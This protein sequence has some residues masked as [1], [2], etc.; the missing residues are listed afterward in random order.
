MRDLHQHAR[1]VA[2]ERVGA[3]GAAVLEVLQDPQRVGDDLVRLAPLHVG[4][5]ADAAGVVLVRGVVEA[6]RLRARR[7]GVLRGDAARFGF[8]VMLRPRCGDARR[9]I[10]HLPVASAPLR[11]D[12]TGPLRGSSRF[13]DQKAVRSELCGQAAVGVCTSPSL[14]AA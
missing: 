6:L 2:G 10:V 8:F 7:P 11:T 14:A 1:A 13:P 4:D 12:L 5:E 9:L 3:D